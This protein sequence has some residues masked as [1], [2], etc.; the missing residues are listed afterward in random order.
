MKLLRVWCVLLL[1]CTLQGVAPAAPIAPMLPQS[2]DGRQ[3]VAGWWLSEKLDGVRGFWDGQR[4]WSKHGVELH[5]P[6]AFIAGLPPFPLE[7]E[8]WGGRGTFA[9]AAGI[10]R[11]QV[12][13]PGWLRLKFAIFDA[14]AVPGPF[15]ARIAAARSWFAEHPSDYAFVI[16]Q[17]PLR[18]LDQLRA[19]L[20]RV[21]KLGGEGLVVR[22]PQALY[23]AGRSAT[24]LKVK[25]A[26]DAEAVVVAH[27]PGKGRLEGMLGALLVELPSGL[28]FRLGTGFSDA[29][30]RHPP[31]VGATITFRYYGFHPSGIPRFASFLRVRADAGL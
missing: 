8:L 6:P 23:E 1:W 2:F 31:P 26:A 11:R 3:P 22:D 27:L 19:Q 14:P 29:E 15:S 12:P 21:E 17:V 25:S 20:K 13:D 9:A 7:G 28:R 10:V 16:D 30:R 4:L 5:P 24:I 18:D